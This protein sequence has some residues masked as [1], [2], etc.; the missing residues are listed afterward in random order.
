LQLSKCGGRPDQQRDEC[1][2]RRPSP[3][4]LAR[5]SR[6]QIAEQRRAR[7]PD[8]HSNLV[9]DRCAE[10]GRL[11]EQAGDGEHDDEDR[12][13][14]EGG[15]IRDRRRLAAATVLRPCTG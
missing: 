4:V 5:A 7:F 14:R 11:D 2:E 3:L 8:Q 15:V 10:R 9:E 13:K 6:E 1:R 12:G